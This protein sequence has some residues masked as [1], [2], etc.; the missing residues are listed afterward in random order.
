MTTARAS[1]AL[2]LRSRLE[3]RLLTVSLAVTALVAGSGIAVG[4]VSGS[5]SILFD[6]MFSSIDAVMTWVT[7]MVA[8]LLVSEGDRRFQ[9]G[10]WQLEPLVL[11]LHSCILILLY[12]YAFFNAVMGILAGG[13]ALEF[14]LAVLYAAVVATACFAMY[15]Y[16]KRANRR[17]ESELIGLEVH[18]WLMSGL[19]TSAL[20]LAFGAALL[21]A[22]TRY[23]QWVPYVDPAILAVL[24]LVLLPLPLAAARRAFT[25]IFGI[26]PLAFDA[27][28]REIVAGIVGRHG[29]AGFTS[30]VAKVGRA[31]FIEVYI[32]VPPGHPMTGVAAFDGVRREIGEAI[33]GAG[34]ERWLTI[35]FTGD[36]DGI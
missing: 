31:R 5:M 2:R 23:E 20:L 17:L 30:Y 33:G 9:F 29:F 13:V 3:T 19:I 35:V 16:E 18:N 11:G 1:V 21:M 27:E 8:R 34:P 28:V 36:A 24:S 22:G 7:L 25:E 32:V 12:G 26:T 14:G 10:Y 6:G 4:L 15:F